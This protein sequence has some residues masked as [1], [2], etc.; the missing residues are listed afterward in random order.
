MWMGAGKVV[1]RVRK[2]SWA[3]RRLA[4][5]SWPVCGALMTG[6]HNEIRGSVRAKRLAWPVVPAQ[7]AHIALGAAVGPLHDWW[8]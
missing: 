6:A 4:S 8:R 1:S 5:Q 2:P 7:L 3:A